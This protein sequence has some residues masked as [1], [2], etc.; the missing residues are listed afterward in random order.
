MQDENALKDENTY[1]PLLVQS[2]ILCLPPSI[3]GWGHKGGNERET[4]NGECSE[5]AER[6]GMWLIDE[7]DTPWLH[8]HEM[9]TTNVNPERQTPVDPRGTVVGSLN[10]NKEIALEDEFA[11]LVLLAVMFRL[12]LKG[13]SWSRTL[14]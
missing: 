8:E 13:T 3:W 6:Q 10:V 12:I 2:I 14:G 7:I 5:I 9:V 4:G 11:F 1:S